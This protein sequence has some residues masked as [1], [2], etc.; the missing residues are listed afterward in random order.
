M[1]LEKINLKKEQTIKV[2][3]IIIYLISILIYEIGICN[4][5]IIKIILKK[6]KYHIISHYVE[7]LFI[8]YL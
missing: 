6:E 8:A 2:I 7:L 1:F 5:E 3:T 4:G